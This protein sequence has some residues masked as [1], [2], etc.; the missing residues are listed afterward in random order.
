MEIM[1]AVIILAFTFLPII[2]TIGTSMKDTDV[3]NSYVFAQTAARNIL[4]YVLDELPFNCITSANDKKGFL[5]E[6]RI[7]NMSTRSYDTYGSDKLAK[8][9][10]LIGSEDE[11]AEGIIKDKERGISYHVVLYVFPIKSTTGSGSSDEMRFTYLKRPEYEKNENWFRY[12]PPDTQ[13]NAAFRRNSITSPYAS[14]LPDSEKV[15]KN[16]YNIGAKEYDSNYYVMKKIV[17]HISWEL[18]GKR[19]GTIHRDLVFYTMKANLDSEK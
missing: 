5:Q 19:G 8:F 11:N 16:A 10:E 9:K 14:L 1:L 2:S 18:K 15:T 4:D 12:S 13:T 7:Y 3:T 17:L 6:A